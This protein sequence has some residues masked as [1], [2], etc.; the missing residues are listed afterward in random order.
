MPIDRPTQQSRVGSFECLA[1]LAASAAWSRR[2]SSRE[3]SHIHYVVR[4]VAAAAV[5]ADG[6]DHCAAG[7]GLVLGPVRRAY[8]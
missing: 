5:P 6:D 1:G 4:Y 8:P 2:G 3:V 7:C